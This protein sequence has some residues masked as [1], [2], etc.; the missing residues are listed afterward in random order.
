MTVRRAIV[1]AALAIASPARAANPDFYGPWLIEARTA[2]FGLNNM[3][4]TL[5]K[6]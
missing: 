4:Y 6:Q 1:L 2:H 3:I 5:R